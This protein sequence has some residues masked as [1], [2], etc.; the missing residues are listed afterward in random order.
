MLR[1]DPIPS[2]RT[3]CVNNQFAL[4]FSLANKTKR[5]DRIRKVLVNDLNEVYKELMRLIKLRR[6]GAAMKTTRRTLKESKLVFYVNNKSETIP[7]AER[8][9]K[10]CSILIGRYKNYSAPI[11]QT[12]HLLIQTCTRSLVFVLYL[13]TSTL[14]SR[15]F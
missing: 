11:H 10:S 13:N 4:R 1:H 6:E 15:V 7:Q 5:T 12:R 3:E 14:L 9:L 2:H 8:S